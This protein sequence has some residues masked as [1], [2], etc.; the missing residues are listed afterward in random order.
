MYSVQSNWKSYFPTVQDGDVSR[1]WSEYYGEFETLEEAEQC[2]QYQSGG[3]FPQL[4]ETCV[5]TIVNE[6][7]QEQ[8]YWL[9]LSPTKAKHRPW[10]PSQ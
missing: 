10:Q 9:D 4:H 6:R 5:I 1:V 3:L 7:T 8:V 2:L